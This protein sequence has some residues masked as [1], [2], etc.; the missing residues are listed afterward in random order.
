MNALFLGYSRGVNYRICGVK[1]MRSVLIQHVTHQRTERPTGQRVWSDGLVQRVANDN[2]L[3]SLTESLERDKDLNWED[4]HQI[5]ETQVDAIRHTIRTSG[6]LE[7]PPRLTIN[8][9]KEDPGT[10]I[11][12]VNLDGQTVRV[13][14]YDPRPKRNP[15][16][17][18]LIQTLK[19]TVR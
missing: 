19:E 18:L 14:V 16:I 10:T 9:C 5:N 4:E 1:Q 15:A 11:W 2:P 13:V 17:D 7:L 8:Y 12:T 3:P 6:F